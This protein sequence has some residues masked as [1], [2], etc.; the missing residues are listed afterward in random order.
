MI[1]DVRHLPGGIRGQLS[2]P[3]RTLAELLRF[4]IAEP[5]TALISATKPLADAIGASDGSCR[6]L[7][8]KRK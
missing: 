3:N 8:E 6:R 7:G 2:G 5:H 1:L 4:D